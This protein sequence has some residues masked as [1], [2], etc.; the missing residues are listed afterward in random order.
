MIAVFLKDARLSLDAI[1]PLLLVTLGFLLLGA[2]TLAL[3]R[4]ALPLGSAFRSVNEVLFAIWFCLS[5]GVVA[6]PAWIVH[7][8]VWGDRTHGGLSL[9]ASIPMRPAGRA[10][11]KVLAAF[12]MT[13]IPP[14]LTVLLAPVDEYQIMG[15]RFHAILAWLLP[16]PTTTRFP[17]PV[18]SLAATSLAVGI[19]PLVRRRWVAIVLVH[20]ALAVVAGSS[21]FA[22]LLGG[23]VVLAAYPDM[24]NPNAF[25]AEDLSRIGLQ[26]VIV[27]TAITSLAFTG[28]GLRVLSRSSERSS[29][30]RAVMTLGGAFIVSSALWAAMPIAVAAITPYPTTTRWFQE[31]EAARASTDE[32]IAD[33]KAWGEHDPTMPGPNLYRLFEASSRVRA[34]SPNEVAGDALA[35]A[36]REA[37]PR[38]LAHDD[39]Q[40]AYDAYVLM[41]FDRVDFTLRWVTR[42]PEHWLGGWSLSRELGELAVHERAP[43][44]LDGA[45]HTDTQ[46]TDDTAPKWIFNAREARHLLD[47]GLRDG[48]LPAQYRE[49]AV[50]ARA[51]LDTRILHWEASTP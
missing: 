31:R 10:I 50:E 11:S 1:R 15:N 6:F 41:P 27:G 48:W 7:A 25:P 30:G 51:A 49:A 14:T 32:L 22:G 3:P 45:R 5:L 2:L 40:A 21:L 46:V 44:T 43:I 19:A 39:Q 4:E 18:W 16:N 20:V 36:W 26:I 37:L 38:A 24:F 12:L 35:D 8:I 17:Y 33:V 47:Q 28:A 34:M 13:S 42:F 29:A 9:A 23:L